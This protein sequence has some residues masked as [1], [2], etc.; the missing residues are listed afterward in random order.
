MSALSTPVQA[1]VP[2]NRQPGYVPGA[3]VAPLPD[4]T[5]SV[6]ATGRAMRDAGSGPVHPR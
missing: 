3:A 4:Y 6:T 2:V 1:G 5:R